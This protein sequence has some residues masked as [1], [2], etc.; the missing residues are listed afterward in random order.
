M[1]PLNDALDAILLGGFLFGLI[2]T[3][4]VLLLGVADLG[5]DHGAGHGH[6][7]DGG[8]HGFFHGMFNVSSILA[9]ITWFGGFGYVARNGLGLWA[10]L[11]ILIALLG[12]FAA[13][14]VVAVFIRMV[15]RDSGEDMDPRA[16]EQ[17]GVLARVT[18]SIRPNGFGEIVY[19]QHGTRQVASAK[20]SSERPIPRDT[21]V[22][23][24]R[25]E[26]GVAIVE[27]FEELLHNRPTSVAS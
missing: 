9:F 21:E 13:A 5:A 10:P 8:D 7:A 23:I 20:G 16:W 26:R 22:V 24:L 2:F 1:F 19:E 25:V 3:V 12:G 4:G 14:A 18:S 11:A 27:P 6:G 15:L 17:V